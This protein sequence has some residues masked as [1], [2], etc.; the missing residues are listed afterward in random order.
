LASALSTSPG[1]IDSDLILGFRSKT[2]PTIRIISEKV[3]FS[4]F[5]YTEEAN[6]GEPHEPRLVSD[7]TFDE[8]ELRVVHYGSQVLFLEL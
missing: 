3:T 5:P 6:T 8:S 2:S 4:L 1:C 7:I